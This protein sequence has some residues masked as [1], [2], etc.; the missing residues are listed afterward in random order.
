MPTKR[1]SPANQAV[2]AFEAAALLGVHFTIPRAMAGKGKLTARAVKP[3]RGQRAPSIYDGGECEENWR[4]YE[5]DLKTDSLIRRPRSW[6]H[7]RPDVLKHLANVETPIAFD[8][9]VG[10]V[11]A[12]EILSVHPS[13]VPRMCRKGY[14]VGRIAWSQRANAS[15][16]WIVSRRSCLAN[17][18]EIKAREAAGKKQG[19]KRTKKLS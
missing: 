15:R 17:V 12:G 18:R 14:I 16:L 6:A 10:V 8:D 7:L 1:K 5:R 4:E 13:L 3:G 19:M 2:G 9:A 11:E